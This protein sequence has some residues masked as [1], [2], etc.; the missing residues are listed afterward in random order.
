MIYTAVPLYLATLV[1]PLNTLF[2]WL[3]RIFFEFF[4]SYGLAIIALTIVIRGLLIPLNVHSQ[5]AMIKQ[6]ALSSQQAEIRRKYPD[7][8]KKQQEEVAKLLSQNG[9]QSFGGCILPFVQLIFIYPIFSVVRGPLR[10][11]GQVSDSNLKNLAKLF[12]DKGIIS[13]S[14]MSQAVSNNIPLLKEL[15]NNTLL[16]QESVSKGFIKMGQLIDMNFMGVNLSLTPQWQ[17]NTLFGVNRAE[18]LPL[19][20]IPVF[21]LLTTLVQ[22]RVANV[23]KPNYREDKEAKERAKLNPARSAQVPENTMENTMKMMN[24]LM[25][26]IM[27]VTTFTFPSAMGFYWIVGNIMGILQQIIIYFLFT[28]PLHEKKAE[29]AILKAHAFSKTAQVA[30]GPDVALPAPRSSG[31]IQK[32]SN[33]G[34]QSNK[35]KKR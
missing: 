30:E 6:Q 11:L 2:G 34:K 32:S 27:L 15:Q 17:P 14:A 10:Y 3:T 23:L 31:N 7:D 18:Y 13:S 8:K 16:L 4:G 12:H 28:K 5:K 26:V 35:R 20:L 22:M 29:M 24:W 1:N 33:Y 9:A 21:V 19:L 25:P